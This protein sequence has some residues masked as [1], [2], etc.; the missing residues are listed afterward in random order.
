MTKRRSLP[1]LPS[2]RWL[3]L[4]PVILGILTIVAF[5]TNRK[6]LVRVPDA[7]VATP[8]RVLQ[9][10]RQSIAPV[11]KG[12]GTAKPK[13]IWSA[14]TEVSGA[15]VETH[16][17]LR[18]GN[19]VAQAEQL[20]N[21]DDEDYRLLVSQRQADLQNALAAVDEREA[22]AQADRLS[23]EIEQNLLRVTEKDYKRF[24]Q[25]Q[26]N[27]AASLSEVEKA[28]SDLLRQTQSAQQL[29]NSLAVSPAQIAAAKAKVALAEAR[30]TE[31]KRDLARTT[32]VAPFAGVLSGVDVEPLQVVASGAKLFE[33]HDTDTIEIEAQFSL[34]QITTL[35][36]AP[37]NV[38][39]R[40]EKANSRRSPTGNLSAI[41]AHR[42]TAVVTARSGQ[43]E[44]SWTGKPIRMSEAINPQTRTLGVV[45]E[46][47]NTTQRSRVT[48]PVRLHP[49]LFCEVT[50]SPSETSLVIT[51][52]RTALTSGVQPST[53][54]GQ[55]LIVDQNNRL[56]RREV[57]LRFSSEK[58]LVVTDGI[59]EGELVVMVPPIP[60]ID[61]MLVLPEIMAAED[62]K[63]VLEPPATENR[64]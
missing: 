14:V 23:L 1:W 60:A 28:R 59:D 4:P 62:Q 44:M 25:L 16:S 30:L 13:R 9:A 50:L 36:M 41:E 12:Y 21:I 45:V 51:I 6:P 35:L 37:S 55:V 53:N 42:L 8:V 43:V 32:I 63:S 19:R 26:G 24:D 2:R 38:S 3:L 61:Q 15:I 11:A 40:G 46:V 17:D 7:E 48:S 56:S 54:R 5:V 39:S 29:R 18:S 33:V 27:S 47:D 22:A 20:V 58:W 10:V 57:S 64:R 49:G 52:P 34:A 31:A